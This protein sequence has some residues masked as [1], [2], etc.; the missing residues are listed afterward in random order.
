MN[1]IQK[2]GANRGLEKFRQL[3]IE[4]YGNT[5]RGYRQGLDVDRNNRIDRDEFKDRCAELGYDQ[6]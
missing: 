3:L 4:K 2:V 6:S 1:R 5:L